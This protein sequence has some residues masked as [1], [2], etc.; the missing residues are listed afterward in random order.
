[1]LCGAIYG[2]FPP[3]EKVAKPP[4][5][6][7]SF[8]F[9]GA[10]GERAKATQKGRVTLEIAGPT[11]AALDQKK[12]RPDRYCCRVITATSLSATSRSSR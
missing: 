1:M 4:K 9:H 12:R 8:V 5:E 11:G 2:R 6:W 10:R 3:S 7:Q